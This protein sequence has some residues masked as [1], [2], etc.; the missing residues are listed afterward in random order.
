MFIYSEWES[1]CKNLDRVGI[2]S[3]TSISL[4]EGN[5]SEK[6][7][8]LKHDVETNPK[9]AL[10]LAKIENKYN[11]RGSYYVQGYLLNSKKNISILRKIQELG[12]EISYH[13]DVMDSNNGNLIM[14]RQEFEMFVELFNSNGFY[15]KTVCQHGNPVIERKDYNSNRDFF[16]DAN[17]RK[18]F[19]GIYEIMVNFKDRVETDYEYL[20]D[21]GY[22]WK[23]IFDPENNDVVDTSKKDIA[24][25]DIEAVFKYIKKNNSIILSTHPHRW[26]KNILRAKVK[27][28]IFMSVKKVVKIL[29]KI[30]FIKK[31][32]NHYYYLAKKI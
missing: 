10:E 23:V 27:K 20:S 22:G 13:H 11:H 8:V 21:S 26:N 17:T 6:F 4:L 24:L 28:Y 1:L 16:R 5:I 14:A 30:P 12:H 2:N 15:I 25:D 18:K 31:L 3:V 29:L 9:K 19:E 32:M 7:L